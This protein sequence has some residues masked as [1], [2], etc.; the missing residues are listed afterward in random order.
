MD[1]LSLFVRIV[2]DRTDL[3]NGMDRTRRDADD[4][5]KNI[6]KSM[7]GIAIGISSAVAAAAAAIGGLV[8]KSVDG[9]SKTARTQ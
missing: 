4:F 6:K 8:K 3:D 2:F 1:L 5:A 7:S 9:F